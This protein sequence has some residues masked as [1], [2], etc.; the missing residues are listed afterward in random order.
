MM[1]KRY[2]RVIYSFSRVD[3]CTYTKSIGVRGSVIGH[4]AKALT[5]VGNGDDESAM[6]SF[7]LVF[8]EGLATENN[9]LLLIKVC[10]D[11]SRRCLYCSSFHLGN[12]PI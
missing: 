3:H 6:R 10:A 11:C 2:F 12:H 4:I 1:P 9:F 5:Y 7:D 8:T